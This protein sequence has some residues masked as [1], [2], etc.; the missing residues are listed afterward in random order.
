MDLADLQMWQA[1]W[2]AN[3]FLAGRTDGIDPLLGVVEEVGELCHAILKQRQGIRGSFEE[4]EA[5]AKD[6]VG[7]I[8]VYL[9][10]LCTRR[11]WDLNDIVNEVWFQVSNRDWTKN[12]ENG[13]P[14]LPLLH[15]VDISTEEKTMPIITKGETN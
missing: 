14:I 3:N 12:K 15:L 5:N 7:D 13:Q 4:H 9:A 11:G 10:D 2:A 6:A 8:I 1:E